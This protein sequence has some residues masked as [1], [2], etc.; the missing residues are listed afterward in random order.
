VG[1]TWGGEDNKWKPFVDVSSPKVKG[2]RELKNL[3]CT[4]SLVKCQHLRGFSGSKNTFS[5]PPEVQ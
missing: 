1:L 2:M 4:I 5:F 3:D